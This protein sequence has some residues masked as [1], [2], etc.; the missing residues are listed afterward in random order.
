MHF[1]AA[2]IWYSTQTCIKNLQTSSE[3]DVRGC[4]IWHQVCLAQC[5]PQ[6]CMSCLFSKRHTGGWRCS[7]PE[8]QITD[9]RLQP[10]VHQE[11]LTHAILSLLY[12]MQGRQRQ[13]LLQRITSELQ[14]LPQSACAPRVELWYRRRPPDQ[15]SGRG[16]SRSRTAQTAGTVTHHGPFSSRLLQWP[17]W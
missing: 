11:P 1:K 7:C 17:R 10:E 3:G 13:P 9:M 16:R 8:R 12:A 5:L 6:W 2:K 4:S 15:N 14:G